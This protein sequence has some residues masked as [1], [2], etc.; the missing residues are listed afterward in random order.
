MEKEITV[1]DLTKELANSKKLASTKPLF[2]IEESI[3]KYK[4]ELT[5]QYDKMKAII[6]EL[7]M[8][9]NQVEEYKSDNNRVKKEN[10]ELQN[11]YSELKIRAN[12]MTI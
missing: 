9:R 6:A 8:Y 10:I 12:K 2:E 11:K 3:K 4:Q 5:R 7:N 1:Q